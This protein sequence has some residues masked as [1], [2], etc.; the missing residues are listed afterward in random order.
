M[1]RR[2][3]LCCEHHDDVDEEDEQEA[4]IRYRPHDRGR[5]SCVSLYLVPT[6]SLLAAGPATTMTGKHADMARR[7]SREEWLASLRVPD[8]AAAGYTWP[9][10]WE[11]H[12]GLLEFL[13]PQG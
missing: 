4:A 8:L 7:H 1:A 9:A 10:E 13:F 6:A 2:S 12:Q 5:L 11:P 3:E